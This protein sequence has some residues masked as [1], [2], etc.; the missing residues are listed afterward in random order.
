MKKKK[1]EQP[2]RWMDHEYA[3]WMEMEIQNAFM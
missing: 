2:N 1:K 3:Q